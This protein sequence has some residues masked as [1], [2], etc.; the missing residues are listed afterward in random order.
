M[1]LVG[2]IGSGRQ[3][4]ARLAAHIVGRKTYQI[5]EKHTYNVADW[6]D[7]IKAAVKAA[8]MST[9]GIVFVLITADRSRDHSW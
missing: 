4:L 7:D 5:N 8:A 3:S 6:K 1:L 2:M 9:N